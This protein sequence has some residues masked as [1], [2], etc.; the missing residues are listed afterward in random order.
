MN[1][2]DI[3]SRARIGLAARDSPRQPRQAPFSRLYWNVTLLAVLLLQAGCATR[4]HALPDENTQLTLL[5]ANGGSWYRQ[6]NLQLAE[7]LA[8][9]T[10]GDLQ[11][12]SA[13]PSAP[14]TNLKGL[15]DRAGAVVFQSWEDAVISASDGSLRVRDEPVERIEGITALFPT[16]ALSTYLVVSTLS[17]LS[18]LEDLQGIYP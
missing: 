2:S 16:P 10:E 18:S 7:V 15:E 17:G 14:L 4:T 1:V 6:V 9:T 11:I 12:M 5:A 3:V 8:T 13:A